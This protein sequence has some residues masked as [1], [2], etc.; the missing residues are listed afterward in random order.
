MLLEQMLTTLRL[1]AIEV[2]AED[3]RLLA[4]FTG[5][6]DVV[7]RYV[8]NAVHGGEPMIHSGSSSVTI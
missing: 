4:L 7:D 3:E 5:I 2:T 8:A 6:A 1:S